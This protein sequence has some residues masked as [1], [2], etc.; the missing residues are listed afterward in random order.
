MSRGGGRALRHE[1]STTFP[2]PLYSASGNIPV[3]TGDA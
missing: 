1:Q 2:V 3:A